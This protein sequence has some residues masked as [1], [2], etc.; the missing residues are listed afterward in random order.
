MKSGKKKSWNSNPCS[1]TQLLLIYGVKCAVLHRVETK[2]KGCIEAP[3]FAQYTQIPQWIRV[4]TMSISLSW[5]LDGSRTLLYSSHT[6]YT[7]TGEFHLQ[8]RYWESKN[9]KGKVKDLLYILFTLFLSTFEAKV[10]HQITLPKD[11]GT[12]KKYENEKC[13]TVHIVTYSQ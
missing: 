7:E 8:K 5:N 6:C 2:H 10:T 4:F 13:S 9:W 3:S 1:S 12:L 11:K